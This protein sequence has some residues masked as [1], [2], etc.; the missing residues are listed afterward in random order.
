MVV[1]LE[2]EVVAKDLLHKMNKQFFYIL[3]IFSTTTLSGQNTLSEL[4]KKYNSKKINYISVQELAMPKTNAIILDAREI[5]EYNVSHIKDAYYVGYNDFKIETVLKHIQ[6]KNQK[7]VVYCS[8][9]IRSETIAHKI[10]KAGFTNVFNLYGGIFE[11]KNNNYP[12]YTNEGLQT[13]NVHVFSNEWSKW[14]KKG[15]KIY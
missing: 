3:I 5:N 10:K 7:I 4:L 2:Q 13:E 1:L 9:G 11:W 12:V 14:L 6:D 8:I 15:V